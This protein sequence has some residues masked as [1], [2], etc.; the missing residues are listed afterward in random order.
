MKEIAFLVILAVACAAQ[1]KTATSQ[2]A[3]PAVAAPS[4][5]V[6][7][8]TGGLA[9]LKLEGF[10][11]DMATTPPSLKI[12]PLPVPPEVRITHERISGPAVAGGAWSLPTGCS[13]V[14]LIRN[15]PQVA[16]VDYDMA[17]SNIAWK[18]AS[19]PVPGDT[20]SALCRR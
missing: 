15:I 11:V 13:L 10:V 18:P 7:L 3:V 4:A 6:V 20:V 2:I 9:V 16:G 19:E 12:V 17:G 14:M 1:T 8:P 5:V